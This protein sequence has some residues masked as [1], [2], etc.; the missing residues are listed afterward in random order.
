MRCV[1]VVAESSL[2]L[3]LLIGSGLM[4]RAFWKLQAVDAGLNSHGL[5]TMRLSLPQAVYPDSFRLSQFWT[6]VQDRLSR[7]AASRRSPW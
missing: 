3:V 5:P 2:S 4:V 6:S 7:C 1:L